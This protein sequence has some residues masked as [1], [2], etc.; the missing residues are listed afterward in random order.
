MR[1][2][3]VTS[4][5][6][7]FALGLADAA[8]AGTVPAD[9]LEGRWQ[10]MRTDRQVEVLRAPDGILH[11]RTVRAGSRQ[12]CA[13]RNVDW[14]LT[15]RGSGRYEGPVAFYRVEGD[16]CAERL[17][18]GH[19]S[20]QL[21]DEGMTATYTPPPPTV[22][23]FCSQPEQWTRISRPKAETACPDTVQA[24]TNEADTLV[25]SAGGELMLG[26]LGDD[27]IGADAGDD[28]LF[29]H[30]GD[31]D[32]T[33]GLG[34]DYLNGGNGTDGLTGSAGNDVLV[35][36]S[37]GGGRIAGGGG[38]DTIRVRATTVRALVYGG[39]GADDITVG[40]GRASVSGGAGAD[41]ISTR[42]K[43]RDVIGCGSGPDRVVVDRRDSAARDCESVTRR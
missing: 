15:A 38:R 14:R 28:C 29:G 32:L 19:G 35:D 10:S 12:A 21:N 36:T 22:C 4:L 13:E 20:F 16:K 41:S 33:G 27:T 26:F 25:G 43:Q 5:I 3:V 8:L 7:L 9:P 30:G 39:A 42:N 6:A 1:A 11:G 40:R 34:D 37:A 2:S 31:D 23:S 17:A 18:D 24:G